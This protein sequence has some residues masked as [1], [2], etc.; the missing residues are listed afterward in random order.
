MFGEKGMFEVG[1][2]FTLIHIKLNLLPSL[3][4]RVHTF[5]YIYMDVYHVY[6]HT[7]YMKVRKRMLEW[8]KMVT[9]IMKRHNR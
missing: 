7:M 9:Y 4:T 3:I 8:E 5:M 6:M 2:E 1:Y